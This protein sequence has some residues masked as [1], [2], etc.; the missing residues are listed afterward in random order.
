MTDSTFT[1]RVFSGIKPSGGLTLGNYLG[2]IKRWVDMQSPD[3]ETVYCAVD[4]HARN[5]CKRFRYVIVG[6]LAGV[7]GIDRID[8]LLG[9]ALAVARRLQAGAQADDDDVVAAFAFI[10]CRIG[11]GRN[12]LLHRFADLKTNMR[13]L[14]RMLI[15]WRYTTIFRSEVYRKHGMRFGL[16]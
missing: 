5:T 9:V 14:Q 1:P 3:M 12:G 4:L 6:Q 16:K 13:T 8:D 10:G 2:A 15:Y 7:L 11:T